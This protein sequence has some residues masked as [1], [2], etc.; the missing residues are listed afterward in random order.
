MEIEDLQKTIEKVRKAQQEFSK[1]TQEQVDKIF[2][3]AAI[4]ANQNRIPLAK[5]AV[6]E[7]G[8]GIV[9]DKVIK[10]HYAA[11]YVYNKYKD[12]KTCGVLEQDD[13]YG[14]KKI[15]E[16][17]GVIAAV[18]P[19][20]NPTSTAIFKT[21]IALKTR[22][23][24]IISPHPR[25][26]QS[27]IAAAKIVLEAAVKAGAPEGIISWIDV[28]SLEL[29]NVLMQS[30]DII[31]ATGG[32]GMVKA[33]YSSGKPALG[34]GPGNTPAVIDETADIVLA[35][36][37]IIHSK[38]FDNGMICASE[39][40]VIVS[41]KIYDRVRDEFMKRGC[42]LLNPEETEKVRKTIIINGALNA[43]IVGQSA[44]TIAQLAGV[45]VAE[46]TKIL[47]GEVESVDLS[48][49]FAHEKLSPVLAMYRASSFDDAV[50]KAYRLIE[51]GGLGHTSSLYINTVTE[52]EKIEK[53]YNTM[54]TCRVLINTP[55]SQG[56]IGDI[57]NFKLAPSLT[58]GCGTWGGNSVSENVG[59]KHLINIKTVAERR[60]NMLWFRA[61]EKVYLKRGCLPVALEE[62]KNVMGKKRVFIVTDT[63][64]YQNGYTKVV[65]DK[66][67][68]MGIV[69]ETFF[70][71]APDP[72]LACA[73]EGAQLIDAFK[74]DCIIAVGGGSAMDAAKIM[75]VMYEHPEIDFLDMAMRFMDIRKRVY[76][77]PKMGEKAYF[78]AVPTSAGTGSEVTPFAVITDETTGQKYPLADYELL[79]KMAIV[80][81]NLM[82]NAPKG[83]T[84]ASGADALVHAIEAYASMMATEFTDGLAIE[85]IKTIFEYLPRAYENGANDPEAREK[86]ANAATMAGMAFA[87]AFLGICHSMGHKLGAYHHLP[88]GIT[89]SLVLDEV[90]R[91]NSAEVPNKMGTFPQYD[92]PHTLRRYAEIAEALN[93]GGANDY[94]KMENLIS[95]I[96]ELKERIGIKKTIREYGIDEQAFLATLD[97]MSEKA[98][99]DQCTGANPR[100]PL[101]SEIKDIY[102]KVYYGN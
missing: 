51:D 75:W 47:I 18:I 41:D 59:V 36:N 50:S 97:E 90:M 28:P 10:N 1:Y 17:I 23:G 88:H 12:I 93:I 24:I 38:T 42:Y 85:A 86:M 48:E 56:G 80:D 44:H 102:L 95:K 13:N 73:K 43:K 64:L 20:T 83:L 63:F 99:D 5:M 35:V 92:H 31:L 57:Y 8:M 70:D 89:V 98:F 14:I 11:E 81:A 7:T 52:K 33:A 34:V 71:V 54:K 6:E 27:T 101:I 77:F 87:N 49:E 21:L 4:A 91:F 67:D 69:H 22:N 58:L 25:A 72:T 62:L 68:E 61:P 53:F 60:E 46:N 30:A 26:K 84:S 37:S 29:T 40:S 15:A 74:P 82:M 19:T 32:P 65:T 39:Q 79:P 2:Q 9:E 16:P 94:E 66:L 78:I 96:D 3:A 100:Y 45:D 55:S 76:T